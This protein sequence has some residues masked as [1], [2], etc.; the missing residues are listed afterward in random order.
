MTSTT[1]AISRAEDDVR[2]RREQQSGDV[3]QLDEVDRVRLVRDSISTA[4]SS[5]AANPRSED[6]QRQLE[7]RA[8]EA[9]PRLK[10]PS[11]TTARTREARASARR[12]RSVS[13]EPCRRLVVTGKANRSVERRSQSGHWPG[14]PRTRNGPGS[15]RGLL[16]WSDCSVAKSLPVR[17]PRRFRRAGCSPRRLPRHGGAATAAPLDTTAAPLNTGLRHL[18]ILQDRSLSRSCLAVTAVRDQPSGSGEPF[19]PF[20]DSLRVTIR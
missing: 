16:R 18:E 19:T 10:R 4:S 3:R 13:L 1:V 20:S 15:R 11:M 17:L 2:R 9:R 14:S 7:R 5:A 12:A 8:G 6:D